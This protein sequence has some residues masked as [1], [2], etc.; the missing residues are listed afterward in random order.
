MSGPHALAVVVGQNVR[1]IRGEFT[2]D[3]LARTIRQMFG[4]KWD[5]GRI[6]GL[7]NGRASPTVTTLFIVSQALSE[8]TR[9]QVLVADLVRSNDFVEVGDTAI[10]AERIADALSGTA[11]ELKLRDFI[12]ADER[13]QRARRGLLD[14]AEELAR[15]PK[16]LGDLPVELMQKVE[17]QT[18]EAEYRVAKS[19]G[20][21]VTRLT[22]ESALLW[23]ESFSV[24]RDRRAG[25]DANAQQR[26]RVSRALKSELKAVLDGD[27]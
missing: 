17:S 9:D 12:D 13:S 24:E 4:L 2:A 19:L 14:G 16:R 15:L 10:R 20:I 11:V 22:A 23:G 6:A 5:T 25:L 7:E 26:G 18:S 1:R 27:D 8:L 21:S 3:S